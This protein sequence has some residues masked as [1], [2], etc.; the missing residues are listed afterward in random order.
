MRLTLIAPA[1]AAAAL[2][3]GAAQAAPAAGLHAANLN[4]V[5]I[6]IPAGLPGQKTLLLLGFRH[7]DQDALDAWRAGLGLTEEATGAAWLEIPVIPVKSSLIQ[8]MIQGGMRKRFATPALRAHV[9]PMF[10]DPGPVA[11]GFGVD[12]AQ[13]AAVV[14]DRS[15]QVL[16][17]AAGPYDGAKAAPLLAALAP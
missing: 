12:P 3:A 2:L 14:V 1:L 8:P 17:R 7:E 13:P 5:D 10:A 6:A 11:A 16:A 9:A 15:G 4:G